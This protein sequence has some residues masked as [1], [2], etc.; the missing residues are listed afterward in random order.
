MRQWIREIGEKSDVA[1]HILASM[2]G[3]SGAD[4]DNIVPMSSSFNNGDYKAYE[5]Y[6]RG[7]LKELS[8]KYPGQ[9]VEARINIRLSYPG[10]SWR[11]HKIKYCVDFY[12]DG[13]LFLYYIDG[14]FHCP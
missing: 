10:D 6:V 13:H 14:I 12:V 11:P 5:F 9:Q 7:Q 8:K 3:G 1:G 4:S 2:L